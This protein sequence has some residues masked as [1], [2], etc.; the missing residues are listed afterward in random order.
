MISLKKSCVRENPVLINISF[1]HVWP[2][3]LICG[4]AACVTRWNL[5]VVG[6]T[7][8]NL[9][10]VFPR[11]PFLHS[12]S[13]TTQTRLIRF[14]DE[15]SF[16]QNRILHKLNLIEL[17][18]NFSNTSKDIDSCEDLV[19]MLNIKTEIHLPSRYNSSWFSYQNFAAAKVISIF[20]VL[21]Y[22]VTGKLITVSNYQFEKLTLWH[23]SSLEDYCFV[24]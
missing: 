19:W 16:T 4:Q 14:A 12:S 24:G 23:R 21:R 1:E 15:V 20:I 2:W 22:E 8:W 6:V 17:I 3:W 10:V 11:N 13:K 18:L 9:H 5:H 7:R